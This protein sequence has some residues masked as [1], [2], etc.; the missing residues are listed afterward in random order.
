MRSHE[1]ARALWR[2]PIL[3]WD[4]LVRGRYDFIYD[5]MPMRASCM[6]WV[7]RRNLFQSGANLLYRRLH[8]W[9]MPLHMQ[10]ELT[11]YCNLRC[12][13]CPTGSRSVNRLP[14]AMEVRLFERLLDEV[15]PY[16]LTTSLWAWG[17]PL[18]HP[19]LREI[20]RAARKYDVVTLLST[21]GQPLA[22]DGIIEALA[23]EP[24]HYLIVAIDGLQNETNSI[25]RV[26]GTIEPILEGVRRL[27]AVKRERGLDRPVLN[28]RY[29]VMKHNH[30]E[31]P[32]LDEFAR[33]NGFE[34]LTIRNMF[35]IE[36]TTTPE[37]RERMAPDTDVW[38]GCGHEFGGNAPRGSF[39]CQEPFW[40]PTVFADGTVVLCEQDYNAELALGR[41]SENV[42]FVDL[43]YS[44]RA[45]QLRKTI[46]DGMQKVSFCRKCPY[47]DRPI[48]DFNV[49]ARSVT[50]DRRPDHADGGGV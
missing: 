18:L 8:P 35:T 13:V 44:E 1:R 26:G 5:Q 38:A 9:S 7:K 28:M 12:P 46:R 50:Q 31:V 36:S 25:Y 39:I 29:I 16:L 17:E 23:D 27:A 4:V 47:L 2:A 37:V 40:F 10:I 6:S 49:E 30:H 3:I 32:R 43:W 11:N 22:R 42:S 34:L 19:R 45:A 14:R 15:G 41:I 33:R 48:T 24:P 20:L 21:N